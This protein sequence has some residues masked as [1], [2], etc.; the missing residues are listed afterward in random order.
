[1]TVTPEFQE[2]SA[3]ACIRA[4]RGLEQTAIMLEKWGPE[5]FPADP[6]GKMH[7]GRVMTDSAAEAIREAWRTA[8]RDIEN[9]PS[10][11]SMAEQIVN[12]RHALG[13]IAD[14]QDSEAGE[15]LDDAIAIAQAALAAKP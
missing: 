3:K 13:K 12:L 5:T 7:F 14:L 9:F 1:M 10:N 11:G 15:P 6:D 8:I 4:L 2:A